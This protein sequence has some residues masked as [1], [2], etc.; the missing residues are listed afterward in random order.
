MLPFQL[1]PTC[2]PRCPSQPLLSPCIPL[3]PARSLFSVHILCRR[4]FSIFFFSTNRFLHLLIPFLCPFPLGNCHLH[5]HSPVV[6]PSKEQ[7]RYCSGSE[8]SGMGHMKSVRSFLSSSL[9]S[10][11]HFCHQHNGSN[12]PGDARSEICPLF[13][14]VML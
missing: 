14:Q 4:S 1:L 8:S 6:A 5:P 11:I 2:L 12:Y 7:G 9:G 3:F 10:N 13:P